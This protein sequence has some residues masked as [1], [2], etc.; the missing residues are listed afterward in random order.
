VTEKIGLKALFDSPAFK[1]AFLKQAAKFTALEMGGE[2]IATVWQDFNEWM[3]LNPG[4]SLDTFLAE[5][6]EAARSTAIATL[7]GAGGQVAVVK[8]AEAVLKQTAAQDMATA[9]ASRLGEVF[10]RANEMLLRERDPVTFGSFF[11]SLAPD[12][13]VFIDT[14]RF[15]ELMSSGKVDSAKLPSVTQE[16]LAES[17]NVGPGVEI[18]VHELVSAFAGTGLENDLVQH[19]RMAPNAETA[20][21]AT[22]KGAEA[23]QLLDNEVRTILQEKMADAAF[24]QSAD[25]VKQDI[26]Q[27]L[28]VA[29]PLGAQYGSGLAKL[30]TAWYVT[31]AKKWGVTP[32]QLRDG[33]TDSQGN[34]QE[35]FRPVWAYGDQPTLPAGF[36]HGNAMLNV[37][38]TVGRSCRPRRSTASTR[39]TTATRSRS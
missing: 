27:R 20:A 17:T 16:A 2:Q 14:E 24:V 26:E 22:A 19:V 30:L 29:N 6:P 38:L 11:Q 3:V 18:P 8:G 28:S 12:A 13:T 21:E 9:D 25:E 5:R 1:N 31:Q 33:W 32:T 23:M 37:G 34:K 36:D 39:M 15:R 4:K 7:I 35:G 10:A